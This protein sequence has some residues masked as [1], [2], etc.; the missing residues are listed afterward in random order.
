M[1]TEDAAP[2]APSAAAARN[3]PK[4]PSPSV[5]PSPQSSGRRTIVT[6]RCSSFF[7]ESASVSRRTWRRPASVSGATCA[8]SFAGALPEKTSALLKRTMCWRCCCL[9]A[10]ASRRSRRA[11]VIAMSGATMTSASS[12]A[13]TSSA[14]SVMRSFSYRF[15]TP[16]RPAPF[17]YFSSSP[18]P[19]LL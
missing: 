5:S 1:R 4:K 11:A 13:K 10:S 14:S 8:C 2:S 3:A 9:F 16:A 6:G 19:A 12:S 15:A 7:Q 17:A 18:L